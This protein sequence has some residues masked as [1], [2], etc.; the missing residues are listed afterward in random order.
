MKYLYW[1]QTRICTKWGPTAAPI[2]K[3]PLWWHRVT[4]RQIK[5]EHQHSRVRLPESICGGFSTLTSTSGG[6]SINR[7]FDGG[8][9]KGLSSPSSF[10]SLESRLG[11]ELEMEQS[12][13][14]L[15][16]LDAWL[17][18]FGEKSLFSGE[19]RNVLFSYYCQ[20]NLNFMAAGSLS[21]SSSFL[22][23]WEITRNMKQRSRWRVGSEGI[24]LRECLLIMPCPLHTEGHRC[25][26][27]NK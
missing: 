4:I 3:Q 8:E 7:G 17:L 1:S 19:P 16:A 22:S 12:R 20:L 26:L 23:F 24:N 27:S 13:I 5:I 6:R 15:E 9:K 25:F 21:I 14:C 18:V 10:D 2:T 11:R